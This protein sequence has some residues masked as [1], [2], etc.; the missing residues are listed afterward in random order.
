MTRNAS[1]V[2][3]GLLA[4]TV[5]L[6]AQTNNLRTSDRLALIVGVASLG[7]DCPDAEDAVREFLRA[8]DAYPNLAGERLR[9]AIAAMPGA[10]VG[11]DAF[12]L[13]NELEREAIACGWAV[14]KEIGHD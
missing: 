7:G 4:A 2:A 6:K 10:D 13:L 12:P 1:L 9:A 11:R 8:V 3:F 14:R 5:A